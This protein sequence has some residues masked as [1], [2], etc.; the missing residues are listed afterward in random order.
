GSVGGGGGGQGGGWGET[1]VTRLFTG[2]FGQ[3][4]SWFLPTALFLLIVT[5]VLL[6][7]AEAARRRLVPTV[8]DGTVPTGT[9]STD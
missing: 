8:T 7:L 3:Q 6:I 1:G 2:S 5:I 4:V 9:R